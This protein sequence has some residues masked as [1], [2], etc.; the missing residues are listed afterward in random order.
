MRVRKRLVAGG[1]VLGLGALL[2]WPLASAFVG[3]APVVDGLVVAPG[4]QTVKDGYVAA[5]LLDAGPDRVVLVDCG[6]TADAAPILAALAARGLGPEAVAGIFLTHGHPDH[7]AGCAAFPEAPIFA[8]SAEVEIV[9]GRAS[10]KGPLPGLMGPL[11]PGLKVQRALDDGDTVKIGGLAVTALAVPGHTE[12]SAAYL[13]GGVLFLGDNATLGSSGRLRAAPWVFSD[14]TAR[15]R[16]SLRALA[17][18]MAGLGATHLAPAHSGPG[19]A[20]A[21]VVWA[22]E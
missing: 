10:T 1:V 3:L 21:L 14:D 11:A 8:L 13:A 17:H 22:A 2:A 19:P 18:R 6:N 7:V 9:E 12:G 20:A 16:A 4:V 5:F 15:N